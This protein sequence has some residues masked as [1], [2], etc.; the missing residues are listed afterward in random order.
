MTPPTV[1]RR[2][3]FDRRDAYSLEYF[4][5]GGTER[6][7]GN[8]RRSRPERRSEWRRITDWSSVSVDL[9]EAPI[10]LI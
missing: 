1:D 8:D 10:L 5:N 9:I 2:S 7:S 4:L 3:G 6:R